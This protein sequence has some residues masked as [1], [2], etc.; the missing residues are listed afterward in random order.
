MIETSL[1]LYLTPVVLPVVLD[2][3]CDLLPGK[4][5]SKIRKLFRHTSLIQKNRGLEERNRW[6][7]NEYEKNLIAVKS[8]I[9]SKVFDGVVIQLRENLTIL[10]SISEELI[11]QGVHP[12][13]LKELVLTLQS[14]QATI[15]LIQKMYDETLGGNNGD[16]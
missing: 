4:Y 10:T 13:T 12:D 9:L 5:V 7:L 14:Q 8:I 2:I 6:D 11:P 16:I 15:D 3:A 1:L